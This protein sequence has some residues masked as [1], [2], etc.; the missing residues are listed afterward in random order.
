L[1]N[2]FKD[3]Q[4]KAIMPKKVGDFTTNEIFGKIDPKEAY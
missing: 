1:N 3:K 2:D 4:I